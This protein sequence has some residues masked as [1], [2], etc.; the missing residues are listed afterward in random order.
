M[1]ASNAL[2]WGFHCENKS[3]GLGQIWQASLRCTASMAAYAML[4]HAGSRICQRLHQLCW[5]PVESMVWRF[6]AHLCWESA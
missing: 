6:K 3:A 1:H 4:A 2:Y 5:N